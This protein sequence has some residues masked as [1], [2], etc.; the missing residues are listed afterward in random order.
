[1]E[2]VAGGEGGGI[3]KAGSAEAQEQLGDLSEGQGKS[4][5]VHACDQAGQ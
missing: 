2:V 1:M 5:E 4:E 3:G